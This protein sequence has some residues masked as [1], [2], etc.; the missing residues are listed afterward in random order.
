MLLNAVH[1]QV[2]KLAVCWVSKPFHFVNYE[3]MYGCNGDM[4]PSDLTRIMFA[5]L[6]FIIL[7]I[8]VFLHEFLMKLA[9]SVEHG[10]Y[11]FLR[12]QDG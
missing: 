6:L 1:G 9:H 11:L 12:W 4:E 10:N 2:K 3:L 7:V 5:K 8:S